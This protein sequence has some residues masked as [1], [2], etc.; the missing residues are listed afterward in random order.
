MKHAEHEPLEALMQR[1]RLAGPSPDL[2]DRVLA[3]AAKAWTEDRPESR[4]WTRPLWRLTAS[5]AAAILLVLSSG[6]C[7]DWALSHWR[8]GPRPVRVQVQPATGD[9]ASNNN[10]AWPRLARTHV[11]VT[12]EDAFDRLLRHRQSLRRLVDEETDR[13]PV[14]KEGQHQ[15]RMDPL[16]PQTRS[17]S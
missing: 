17:L 2:R 6:R 1:C 13:T 15:G 4:G 7:S 12:P 14:R 11:V 10:L 9:L 5:V 8:P 16:G 3:P